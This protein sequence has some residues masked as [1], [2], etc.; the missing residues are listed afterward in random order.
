MA[1][2]TPEEIQVIADR[3]ARNLIAEMPE[4]LAWV[5]LFAE[6]GHEGA[7]RSNYTERQAVE[8]SL[9]ETLRQVYGEHV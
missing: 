4:G 6:P 3:L 2:F 5:L 7:L 8:T 9:R 1:R